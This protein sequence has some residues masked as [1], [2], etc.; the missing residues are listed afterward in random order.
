MTHVVAHDVGTE[1]ISDLGLKVTHST[2]V[3]AFPGENCKYFESACKGV[4]HCLP[5]L[6]QTQQQRL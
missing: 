4:N 1:L 5:A 6:T 3:A 2:V